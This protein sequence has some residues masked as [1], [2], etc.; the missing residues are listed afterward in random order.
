MKGVRVVGN[1]LL[2]VIAFTILII[3]IYVQNTKNKQS[4]NEQNVVNPTPTILEVSSGSA[5]IRPLAPVPTQEGG[6]YIPTIEEI[7]EEIQRTFITPEAVLWANVIVFCESGY[8]PNAVN[9]SGYY[10]LFQ[11]SPSTYKNCGGTDIWNW[12]EQIMITKNCMFDHGRQ[13]EFPACNRRYQ[14]L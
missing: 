14:G 2:L 7:K 12:R 6:T 4:N 11:Y 13:N 1:I 3:S 10:G 9:P 5:T 8:N